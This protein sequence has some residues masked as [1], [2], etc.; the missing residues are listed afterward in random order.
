MGKVPEGTG[1]M[2]CNPQAPWRT[3]SKG[4]NQGHSKERSGQAKPHDAQHGPSAR[5][6]EEH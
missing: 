5:G 3:L 6:A 1:R 4:T 2:L